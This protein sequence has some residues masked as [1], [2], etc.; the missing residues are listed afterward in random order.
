[1][2]AF[3]RWIGR[4][5]L[6]LA[7]LFVA[8]LGYAAMRGRYG[9]VRDWP[10]RLVS[11]VRGLE[12][13]SATLAADAARLQAG[14]RTRLDDAALRSVALID[15]RRD[16]VARELAAR[17]AADARSGSVATQ[18]LAGGGERVVR[19]HRNRLAIR[20]LEIEAGFLAD[21]RAPAATLSRYTDWQGWARGEHARRHRRCLE[22]GAEAD[23]LGHDWI[24][25]RYRL[26]PFRV[27]DRVA[28]LRT[29]AAASCAAAASLADSYR[30]VEGRRRRL[31]A[32]L[33][34]LPV[35]AGAYAGVVDDVRRSLEERWL[36]GARLWLRAHHAG[37]VFRAALVGVALAMLMPFAIRALFF[38]V[39]APAAARR[40]PIRLLPGSAAMG[41]GHE[42]SA[43]SVDVA[44]PPGWELLAKQ[45][46]LHRAPAGAAAST[47][48]LLSR[49]QPVAS[50]VRKLAFL[51]RYRDA[52][53]GA[54]A[55]VAAGNEPFAELLRLP[56]AE[57]QACTIRPRL[58]VAVLQPAAR[59]LRITGHWRLFSLQ[60]WLTLQLRFLVFHGPG[61]LVLKGARG[62]HAIAADHDV[63]LPQGHLVG[64]SANLAH[65]VTRAATFQPYL[66][67]REPLLRD[68]V[69]QGPG[70]VL[71]EEA[72]ALART[73]SG[74]GVSHRL[75]NALDVL[76]KFFGL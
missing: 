39:L 58:I 12:A 20:A 16:A 56:L 19:V 4:Y 8:G 25:R 67:G 24:W 5:A 76:L 36:F 64:F 44:L 55:T 70:I 30:Q 13:A 71:V 29:Q 28:E 74:H 46:Y 3:A 6:L 10:R 35:A 75:E 31:E 48:W 9:A 27:Q 65:G 33:H 42:R 51:T 32:G 22:L 61:L 53:A 43:V 18:L 54:E 38:A 2:A 63:E 72:P 34:D 73:R 14:G 1:M 60:A 23:R 41:P 45:G 40:P 17:R 11:D 66:F 62:L 7:L 37:S 47:R 49:R 26:Q 52:P 68:R 21:A 15:A 69:A 50:L 57:G 59:P